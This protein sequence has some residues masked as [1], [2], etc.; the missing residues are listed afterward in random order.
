MNFLYLFIIRYHRIAVSLVNNFY[1]RNGSNII[2]NIA[3]PY[4][5]LL[6]IIESLIANFG[7]NFNKLDASHFIVMFSLQGKI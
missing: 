4:M 5:F 3:N 6:N 7:K 2:K 1:R